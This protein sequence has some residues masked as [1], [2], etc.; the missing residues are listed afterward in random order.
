MKRKY[1]K[2]VDAVGIEGGSVG[3]PL[4]LRSRHRCPQDALGRAHNTIVDGI[5][6]RTE[7]ISVKDLRLLRPRHRHFLR[8][9]FPRFYQNHNHRFPPPLHRYLPQDPVAL[10]EPY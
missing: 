8:D 4:W 10:S 2:G 9:H 1:T 6:V 3:S 5:S 7:K